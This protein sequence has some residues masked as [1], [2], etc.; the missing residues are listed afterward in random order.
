MMGQKTNPRKIPRTQADVDRAYEQGKEAGTEL[1]LTLVMFTMLD[2]FGATED[3]LTEFSKAFH[4]TLDSLSRGYITEAD[5]RK[6]LKDEY[7]TEIAV[8]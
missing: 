7:D 5:L 8:E 4:Y 2:R 3:Q 1:C 6:V